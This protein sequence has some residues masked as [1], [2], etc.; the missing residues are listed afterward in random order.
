LHDGRHDTQESSD[1]PLRLMGCFFFLSFP[2]KQF[3]FW[4]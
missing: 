4:V 3:E 1:F 2:L